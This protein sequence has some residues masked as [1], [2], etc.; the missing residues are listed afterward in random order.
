MIDTFIYIVEDQDRNTIKIGYSSN[1]VK[2]LEQLQTSNSSKLSLLA[3]FQGDAEIEK[4]IHDDLK[5]FNV[6]GEWFT[7]CDA[8]FEILSKYQKVTFKN[9]SLRA[10]EN[11]M[12]YLRI[13]NKKIIDATDKLSRGLIQMLMIQSAK[14]GDV[15][16]VDFMD[17]LKK[18]V[19][20][21][22]KTT[23]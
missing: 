5:Y 20:D 2:R 21:F 9:T 11:D 13:F 7:S 3:T 4:A 10:D 16:K 23:S 8:V 15:F 18:L 12:Q 14:T 22:N 17:E 1:P 19:A 6:R